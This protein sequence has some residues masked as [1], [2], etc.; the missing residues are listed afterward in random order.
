MYPLLL[1]FPCF[2]VSIF[3][4]CRDAHALRGLFLHKRCF[5]LFEYVKGP[6]Y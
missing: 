3:S 1:M 5:G 2:L 6:N 4:V